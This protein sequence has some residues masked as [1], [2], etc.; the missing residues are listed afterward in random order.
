MKKELPLARPTIPVARPNQGDDQVGRAGHRTQGTGTRRAAVQR[1]IPRLKS[2][3]HGAESTSKG[4][5]RGPEMAIAQASRKRKRKKKKK[6]KHHAPVAT[7][8]AST[9]GTPAPPPP[10]PA[11]P[12]HYLHVTGWDDSPGDGL[13]RPVYEWVDS[14]PDRHASPT[15]A[16]QPAGPAGAQ[17][18][19]AVRRLLGAL[20]PGAGQAAARPG[21]IRTEAGSGARSLRDGP[22]GRRPLADPPVGHGAPDRPRAG[23]RRRAADR[24]DRRLGP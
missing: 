15:P 11:D 24:P 7:P 14:P 8:P 18:C 4:A 23:R 16:A 19:A 9:P 2:P 6:K 10:P 20:R 22:A 13:V 21:R 5:R 12:P 1:G 17:G 3:R